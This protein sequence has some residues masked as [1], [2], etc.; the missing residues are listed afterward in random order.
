MTRRVVAIEGKETRDGRLILPGAIT[1]KNDVIPVMVDST[2]FV[3]SAT[4]FNR[5][6]ETGEISLDITL[7]V[8]LEG[9]SEDLN[10]HT[11]L[12]SLVIRDEDE[13]MVIQEATLVSLFMSLG[14]SAWPELNIKE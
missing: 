11:S 5:N 3:G 7:K 13:P 9:I 10:I 14:E 6:E 2:I 4:D 8:M 12:Y 1:M